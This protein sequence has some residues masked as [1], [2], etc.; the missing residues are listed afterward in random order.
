MIKKILLPLTLLI[1]SACGSNVT[2]S[3]LAGTDDSC[4]GF[5]RPN[6]GNLYHCAA[7]PMHDIQGNSIGFRSTLFQI[8][9]AFNP[10]QRQKI[11]RAVDLAMWAVGEH[12]IHRYVEKQSNSDF[13]KCVAR[14]NP[15]ELVPVGAPAVIRGKDAAFFAEYAMGGITIL[16]TF[17]DQKRVP[18]RIRVTNQPLPNLAQAAQGK[19]YS[20]A[21]ATQNMDI[22]V[23]IQLLNL[24]TVNGL[25]LTDQIL[26]GIIFHEWLH[27]VG[28]DHVSGQETNTF[29]RAAG[30]CVGNENR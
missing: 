22:Q 27:R 26:A 21:G 5:A 9:S 13:M 4:A 15:I 10:A 8:S 2:P 11:A 1:A 7:Y 29:I 6:D 19:D 30:E 28:F 12:Y 17:H 25:P 23:N 14:K 24:G 16:Q 18:A 3:Q 20:V